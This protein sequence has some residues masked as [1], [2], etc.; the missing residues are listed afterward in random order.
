MSSGGK[1][2]MTLHELRSE[3]EAE[4]ADLRTVLSEIDQV[5]AEASV[6]GDS[7]AVRNGSAALVAQCYRGMENILKRIAKFQ[8]KP[9][10]SGADWHVALGMIYTVRDDNPDGFIQ[11][12]LLEKLTVMRR[13]RHVVHHGYG[14]KLHWGTIQVAAQEARGVVDLFVNAVNEYLNKL[15]E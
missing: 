5:L 13:F 14:F 8:A 15:S 9:I 3:V 4:T 6:S 12:S 11:G 1:C 7:A 2:F 10:P